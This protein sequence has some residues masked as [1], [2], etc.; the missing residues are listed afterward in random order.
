MFYIFGEDLG[1]SFGGARILPD[2]NYPSFSVSLSI[3]N[4]SLF[5]FRVSKT[6]DVP[7]ILI[8]NYPY[9]SIGNFSLSWETI[10]PQINIVD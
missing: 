6:V 4:F 1:G 2:I 9:N 3:K 7:D 10:N 5:S 8:L